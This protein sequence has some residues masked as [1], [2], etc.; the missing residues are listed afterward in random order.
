MSSF[1][2]EIIT[3]ATRGRQVTI[4]LNTGRIGTRKV[5]ALQAIN[6]FVCFSSITVFYFEESDIYPG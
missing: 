4:N 2:A 1:V 3:T 5:T 6:L